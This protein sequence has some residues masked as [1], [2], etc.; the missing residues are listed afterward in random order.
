[1]NAEDDQ[2]KSGGLGS[3]PAGSDA[4]Y[5][6]G[7]RYSDRFAPEAAAPGERKKA[8]EGDDNPED[9]ARLGN[10]RSREEM[11]LQYRNDPRF[12]MLFNEPLP[13][14][15]FEDIPEKKHSVHEHDDGVPKSSWSIKVGGIRL[16]PVRIFILSIF[17]LVVLLCLGGSLFYAFKD[18]GKY[19]DFSRA[20]ALLEAGDYE[21]AKSLFIK[22]LSE[23]PNKEAAVRALADIFHHFG[24][25]NNEAFLRQRI[26]RLNPLDPDCFHD[27]LESAFRGRNFGSIYSVLNLKAMETPELPPDEG[28]LYLISALNSGHMSTGRAFCETMKK[29]NP[30]YFSD[31]E[32]GRFAEFLLGSASLNRE[33]VWNTIS[34]LDGIQDPQVRFETITVLLKFLSAQG[35]RESDEEME[36]LLLKATELNDFAGAPM[37][38]NYYFMHYRFDDTIRICD[39]YL[40]TKINAVIPVLY[41]ESC[42]LGGQPE[43]ILPMADKIRHLRGRQSK[44]IA[45][46]LDALYAFS[47][48]DEAR[49]QTLLQIAGPSFESPLSNLMRLQ[50]ALKQNSEKDILQRLGG[51]MRG[52]PFFDFQQRARTVALQYL[53]EKTDSDL[54]SDPGQLH[55]CAEV[56]SLIRTPDDNVSFLQR[57]ILMN[58]FSRKTMTEEDLLSALNMFPG[59]PVFLKIAAQFFLT[60]GQP[61]RAMD[62]IAESRAAED[63][64]EKVKSSMD[65]LHLLALDQLGRKEEAEKEF[66]GFVEQDKDEKL[67]CP[68]F[69]FCVEN[70]FIDSLRSLSAWIDA[71]PKDSAMR[72]VRPFV[73]A[74][75]LLDEGK[76]EQA[77]NLFEKSASNDPR[78]VFHAASRLAEAGRN[79][80]AFE[81]FL[82]I[83]DTYPDKALVNIN[84]SELYAEKGDAEHALATARTAWDEDENN[85]LARYIYATRLCE[86][87]QYAEA[88]SVLRFP[89][90][91]ASFPEE[92]LSLWSKAIREQIKADFYA[93][94]Y[95]PVM[96]NAKLLLLYFPDDLFGKDYLERVERIRRHETVGGNMNL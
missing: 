21:D 44:M 18:L 68:Y 79:D 20:S 60:N 56:A 13:T 22:V 31:T 2:K 80:A 9:A 36:K 1:M 82:S 54:I 66:R 25:W 88:V 45:A 53:L 47:E 39:E 19:R 4:E 50:L 16:T 65:V 71:L 83:K 34:S 24:D 81:R 42:V 10:I 26:M 64:P 86:A 8:G 33:Q 32:R 91:K 28:A 92:M 84:L 29:S 87:K 89:Q 62:Y 37:L 43:S 63:F 38:A 48:G 78:F 77:L 58:R 52:R 59:D 96:E 90:Y 35:D 27:F 57:I 70:G 15:R 49:M 72:A 74:E 30:K 12:A 93:E 7:G 6:D 11:E 14:S 69:E 67:L 73:Q 61:A 55:L 5:R 3:G 51:I 85:L 40:K 46:H 17:L 23:D 75:I 95:T 76:K 94:R 41:G